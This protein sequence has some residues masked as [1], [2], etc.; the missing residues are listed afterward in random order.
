MRVPSGGI[1]ATMQEP[2][3]PTPT[4]PE[5]PRSRRV[6]G[7][8]DVVESV[9]LMQ[10][11]E[12]DHIGRWRQFVGEVRAEVLPLYQG[13]L[14]KSLGDGM[15]LEF[16]DA[17]RALAGMLDMQRRIGRY[18]TAHDE[19]DSIALRCGAH[20]ADVV[21]DELDIYGS[22][23]NLAAR[24]AG[25]GGP[26]DITVSPELREECLD[27]VDAVFEDLGEVYLKHIGK[28]VHAI[29]ARPLPPEG[30]RDAVRIAWHAD[31]LSRSLPTVAVM[32]FDGAPDR[33]V[34]GEL[35]A[36][37]VVVHL[38]SSNALRVISRLSASA[39]AQRRLTS[40]EIGA[41]LGCDYVLHG[42][43]LENGPS[44]ALSVELVVADS[45]E[46]A[47]AERL[48]TSVAELLQPDDAVT[49]ELA[50]Q[51]TVAIIEHEL[52]HVAHAPLPTLKDYSLQLAAITLMHRSPRRE[53]DR[54]GDVLGHLIERHPRAARPRALLA[55]WHVLR[56]TRGL[57]ADLDEEGRRALEQ[58]RRAIDIDADD[59]LPLAVEAFV[60]CH[61]LRDLDG[62]QSRLDRALE[63]KPNEPLAWLF[64][65]VVHGFR[66]DGD[67]AWQC[68][69]RAIA[70]S[71]LDPMRPYFDGL[72]A[73][74]ALAAGLLEPAVD[75]AERSL[76]IN[77][78]HLPTL[79]ALAIGLVERGDLERARQTAARV[80]ALEPQFTLREYLVRSPRGSGSATRERY[81]AALGA[82]GIPP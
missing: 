30:T 4:W 6:I 77:R 81:V 25:V 45:G 21:I 29:S 70:L 27:G 24:L 59:A 66:G 13:R 74:A 50:L 19:H 31:D 44:V 58:T 82:A 1:A 34:L 79:R 14:V 60:H 48:S 71:P 40:R 32:P 37:G 67:V 68:A 61:V 33:L 75:L 16:G 26:G 80:L 5:L 22:G 2:D 57:A 65:C 15:L 36:D 54:A 11:H 76:R 23:V 49:R 51:T 7:V 35:V 69:R 9:R 72:A 62:A 47:W 20:V 39:L 56:V 63:L 53:F 17:P 10:M 64:Q 41:L 78:N 73:S 3:S 55:Q 52:R 8:V 43:C 28:P 46:V 18:N 12:D 38:A 42:R